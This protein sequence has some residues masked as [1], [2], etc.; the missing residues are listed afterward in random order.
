MNR[1][2]LPACI[3]TIAGSDSGAGAGLQAD[4]RTIHALGGFAATVVTAVTAQ[5]TRGV[6]AWQAVPPGLIRAQLRAVLQDLPIAAIKTGLLPG[7][8]AIRIIAAELKRRPGIALVV[9]PVI[10]STSGTRFL[11]PGG[12]R[13]LE[14]WLFPLASLVTPNWPE[15]AAL[16]GMPVRSEGE[17]RDAARELAARHGCAFL[18]KGGHGRGR[19]SR[20]ILAAGRKTRIFSGRRVATRNTH[21][22]GCVLSA[23][24]AAGLGSGRSLEA[25][26][27]GARRFLADGLGR[28][29]REDWGGAG[30]AFSGRA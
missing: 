2:R 16:S 14:R 17:A 23:S 7:P 28:G 11:S 18:V 13:A 26:V 27:A 30:P 19:M 25:A 10:G 3:L 5:N 6:A 21:G 29:R 4:A 15:A 1:R 22:T 12:V 24:I 8:A 20:D 9:D